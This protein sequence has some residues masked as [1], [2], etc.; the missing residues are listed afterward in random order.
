MSH[1]FFLFY[2]NIHNLILNHNDFKYKAFSY[3]T[4]SGRGSRVASILS[5]SDADILKRASDNIPFQDLA[6]KSQQQS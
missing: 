2:N 3:A 5:G 4:D 6:S 1:K